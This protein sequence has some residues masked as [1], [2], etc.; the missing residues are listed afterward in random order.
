MDLADIERQIEER[1]QARRLTVPVLPSVAAMVLAVINDPQSDINSLADAIRRD[2]SLAGHVVKYANA[3]LLRAG[4]PV[5]TVGQAIARLGMRTVGDIVFAACI[6]PRLFPVPLY[7]ARIQRIWQESLATALWAHEINLLRG[8]SVEGN[9]LCGLLHHVGLP[10]VLQAVQDILGPA[11]DPAPS[12][13][14]IETLLRDFGMRAGLDVATRWRLPE[15]VVEVIEYLHDPS[16]APRHPLLVAG[17][18]AARVLASHTLDGIAL[19]PGP[20]ATLPQMM[21]AGLDVAALSQLV[22]RE[23][24]VQEILAQG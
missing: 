7:A 19:E 12:D 6:G 21:T 5:L 10:V 3:P 22:E 18:A 23:P 15:P 13:D 11:P 14:D 8:R 20:L 9:F 1:L 16:A 4:S 2:Q 17:V 24:S